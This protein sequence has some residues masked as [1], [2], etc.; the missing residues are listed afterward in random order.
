MRF[1]TLRDSTGLDRPWDHD[2]DRI[3]AGLGFRPDPTV[4]L[5]ATWQHNVEHMGV[6]GAKDRVVDFLGLLLTV[7]F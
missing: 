3:E 5:K 6:P 1:G 4:R 2:R 7:G